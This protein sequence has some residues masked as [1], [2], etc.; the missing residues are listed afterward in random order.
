MLI[1]YFSFT[2][3]QTNLGFGQPYG[4]CVGSILYVMMNPQD[5]VQVHVRLHMQVHM[6]T[7]T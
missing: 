4:L 1:L 5:Q 3:Q 7:F 6:V 2:T